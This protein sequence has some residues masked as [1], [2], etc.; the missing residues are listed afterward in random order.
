MISC[1]RPSVP[2]TGMSVTASRTFM[3]SGVGKIVVPSQRLDFTIWESLD[4]EL[5][6][7]K[8]TL[9]KWDWIQWYILSRDQH[10]SNSKKNP[11]YIMKGDKMKWTNGKLGKPM[12]HPTLYI[13]QQKLDI[14]DEENRNF[15]PIETEW[16]TENGF[17]ILS[18][19][20]FYVL[21][22]LPFDF[23]FLWWPFP[24]SC[25]PHLHPLE[26]RNRTE[27]HYTLL[28]TFNRQFTV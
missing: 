3:A 12:I 19:N 22:Y 14:S 13:V 24:S 28:I 16:Q 4:E 27:K 15:R 23:F 21:I 18:L 2:G 1:S 10:R 8:R 6:L 11:G 26:R 9:D 5:M 17:Q 25:R 7:F 20:T